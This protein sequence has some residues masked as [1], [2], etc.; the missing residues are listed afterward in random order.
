MATLL[1]DSYFGGTN[2]KHFKLVLEY[3]KIMNKEK[4]NHTVTYYLYFQSLDGYSGS[5]TTNSV[6]GYINNIHVGSVSSIGE[7]TKLLLG[8]KT[9]TISHDENLNEDRTKDVSYSAMIDTAWTLGDASVSG[10][11]T[12]PAIPREASLT[13]SANLNVLGMETIHSLTFKNDGNMYLK[14]EY[15]INDQAKVTKKIGN[16]KSYNV[17]FTQAEIEEFLKAE[18]YKLKILSY[19]NSAYT[20]LVGSSENEG[21]ITRNGIFRSKTG[22]LIPYVY[23]NNDWQMCTVFFNGKKGV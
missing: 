2:D 10:E 21:N 4:N 23:R 7:N 18:S 22:I 14:L 17:N 19:S 3:D 20:T 5:G 13:S 9:E 15:I 8:T 12:L 1:K 6:K 11:L 16:V